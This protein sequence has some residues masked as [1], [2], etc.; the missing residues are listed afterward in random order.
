M[1]CRMVRAEHQ[2]AT[3]WE[4]HSEVRLSATPVTAVHGS[5]GGVNSSFGHLASLSS[6]FLLSTNVPGPRFVP[7]A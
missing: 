3:A 1:S 4:D 2:F 7:G 5:Q 6:C